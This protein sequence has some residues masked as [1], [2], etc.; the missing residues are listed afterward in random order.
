M[1]ERW[2]FEKAVEIPVHVTFAVSDVL[3][4]ARAALGPRFYD[5]QEGGEFGA[6][7]RVEQCVTARLERAQV[8]E[9]L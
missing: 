6:G 3:R 8:R 4:R 1:R 2:L 5:R 9:A 7:R